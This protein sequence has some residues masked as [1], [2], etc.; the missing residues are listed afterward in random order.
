[1]N[2]TADIALLLEGTYPFVR[3]GVSSWVHQIITGLPQVKFSLIFVG[4][5]RE[6]YGDI[7]YELPK[8]VVHL[9]KHYLED[10]WKQTKATRSSKARPNHFEQSAQLH[11]FLKYSSSSSQRQCPISTS[12]A[13]PG[14]RIAFSDCWRALTAC[15]WTTT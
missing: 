11:D 1:V 3:G 6:D 8:N 2:E 10:A 14:S 12:R 9:E 5:R 4:G 7:R 15:A 13:W